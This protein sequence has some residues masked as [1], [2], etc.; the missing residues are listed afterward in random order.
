MNL[1]AS[2]ERLR[3]DAADAA[4]VRDLVPPARREL[5]DKVRQHISKLADEVEQ[6]MKHASTGS[7]GPRH[8]L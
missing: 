4:L 7:T 5:Y 2:L 1:A 6:A 3:K 8:Q